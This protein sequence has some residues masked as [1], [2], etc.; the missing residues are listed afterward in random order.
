MTNLTRTL[1]LF[2]LHHALRIEVADAA[3][4]SAGR[5]I[6][7]G[8]DERRLAGIH[9]LVD[10]A[11]QFVRCRSIH[12]DATERLDDLVVTRA[13]HEHR[14]R[15]VR[16]GGI[17]IGAAIDA[18]VVEDDDADRQLVT[19][20]RFHFHAGKT[21]RAVAFHRQYRLAGLDRRGDRV[22]HADA[23]DAPGADVEALARLIHVDDAAREIERVGA[24]V[25]QN[26]IRP[27]FD[28]GA[29]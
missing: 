12:A 3:A 9:C 8:I 22:T 6:D 23:H 25:D 18:V 2:L 13:F 21:E 7:H 19:A 17:N 5:R 24:L 28:D 10:G 16:T 29:Q 11:A 14:G 27:L 26:G 15:R 4:F 1:S 20:D